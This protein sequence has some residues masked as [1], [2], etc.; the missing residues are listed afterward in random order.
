M[1]DI[2]RSHEA[3]WRFGRRRFDL[4]ANAPRPLG[5]LIG[6]APG[7]NTSAR[8]PLF[9]APTNSSACRLMRYAE[10]DHQAWMSLVRVNLCD[11]PWSTRRALA[12]KARA[13]AFLLARAKVGEPL[14]VLLLGRRVARTWGCL[15]QFGSTTMVFPGVGELQ[16]AWIPHPSGRCHAYNDR[17][18]Q[19]RARRAVQWVSG[20][21]DK[22]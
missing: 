11:G 19:L 15:G 2:A 16:V 22:P 1:T 3:A 10:F 9:P 21:R 8:L 13:L 14:R 17:R 4:A 6:E 5:M 20:E 7:P 12:G 18:N